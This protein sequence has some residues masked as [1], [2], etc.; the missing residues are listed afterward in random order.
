MPR[1]VR[2]LP[3]PGRS[4]ATHAPTSKQLLQRRAETHCAWLDE[5]GPMYKNIVVGTDGSSRALV[6]V[7]AAVELAR[8]TG[9]TV[10]VV[11]AHHVL[12]TSQVALAGDV[13]MPSV[14]VSETNA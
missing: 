14:D 11:H 5:G 8:L 12:S 2:G 7:D 6:A 4:P 13:P 9:A 3:R 1:P 10:H